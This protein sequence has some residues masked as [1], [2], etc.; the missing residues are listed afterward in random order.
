MEYLLGVVF[1]VLGIFFLVAPDAAWTLTKWEN[2]FR[3]Q[4]SERTELWEIRR[5]GCGCFLLILA[6]VAFIMA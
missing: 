1:A 5:G 2:A 3:G 6:L 4:K